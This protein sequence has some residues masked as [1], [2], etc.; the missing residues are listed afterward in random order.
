MPRHDPL[1]RMRHMRDHARE[2]RQHASGR[3]RA[4][5]DRDRLLVLVEV[6]GEAA[7]QVPAEVRERFPSIPWRDI[8]GMRNR[9]IH[10]YDV[11]DLDALWDT[12]TNDLPPLI[13]QLEA[14]LS[15][16]EPP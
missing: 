1:V 5:L 13:A 2:A 9:L 4:D 7:S 8:I 14:A 3:T 12:V 11:V 15:P 6:I 16:S 10:G